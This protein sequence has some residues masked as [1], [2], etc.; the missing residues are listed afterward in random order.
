[1]TEIV[2]K[3]YKF[4]LLGSDGKPYRLCAISHD[5]TGRKQLEATLRAA[6]DD[7]EAASRA[8]TAFLANISHE[9]RTP[10]NAIIGNAHL[11][12]G[13]GL[14]GRA[15]CCIANYSTCDFAD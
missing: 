10:I 13:A 14:T 6:R 5:V 9:I 15:R 8:K 12:L 2:F 1:V 3:T 4:P 7:A 11:A